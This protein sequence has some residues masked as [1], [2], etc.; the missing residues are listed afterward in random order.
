MR[1][2]TSHR[3]LRETEELLNLAQEAGRLGIF[4][5]AVQSGTVRLS[6][7]FVS[8]YGLTDYD[9]TYENWLKC[10][11]RE[12]LPR[13]LDVLE[14]AFQAKELAV[15]LEFRI[16]RPSDGELRWIE[17]RRIIFYGKDDRP[18]RVVGVSVDV[19]ERKRAAMQLR[20]FTETLEE[21]VRERTAKLQLRQAQKMEAVGQL[22]GGVA[23]DFNNLLTVIQG[24]L[25]IIGRQVASLGASSATS[26][27]LRGKDMAL[28]GV[29]R[30]GRL[31]E[32]LLAFARQQPLTPE[33]VDPNR[34]VGA[35]LDA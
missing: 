10:I 19:T 24:G 35:L 6:P 22:T 11:F 8:I 25:E 17:S 15:E 4:E 28:E 27:I 23:H 32:R 5:W 20:A 33:V 2:V 18:V 7:K 3:G 16:V 12:D 34:L 31:T 30:A 29:L 21:A 14:N 26:R 13:Y 9:G 1:D